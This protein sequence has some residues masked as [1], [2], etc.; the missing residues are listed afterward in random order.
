MIA[1]D[2]LRADVRAYADRI[3]IALLGDPSDRSGAELRFGRKG[4][5]AVA[6]AGPKAGVWHDFEAKTGGDMLA[7]IQREHRCDFMHACEIASEILA[8]SYDEP[9]RTQPPH[10]EPS[11]QDKRRSALALFK[12]A[13]P[14]AGTIAERYLCETRRIDLDALP[15]LDHVLRFHACCPFR[16]QQSRPCLLALWRGMR[17]VL[18]LCNWSRRIRLGLGEA[19]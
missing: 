2:A 19:G 4:S 10:K 8:R 6:I 18:G 3:A 7:L 1:L 13:R 17:G 14:I 12:E 15:N 9:P 5:L 16:P 11:D